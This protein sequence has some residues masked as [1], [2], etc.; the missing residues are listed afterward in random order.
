MNDAPLDMRM[1]QDGGMTAKDVVN[2]YSQKELTLVISRYGRGK[3][4]LAHS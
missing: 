3:M 4:G 2:S 1:D